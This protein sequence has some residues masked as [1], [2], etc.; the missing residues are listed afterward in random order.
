[1]GRLSV[2]AIKMHH[3]VKCNKEKFRKCSQLEKKKKT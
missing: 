1:M 3:E 2:K